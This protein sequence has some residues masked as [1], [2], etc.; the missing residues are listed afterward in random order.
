MIVPETHIETNAVC[1]HK[2][3]PGLENAP[4]KHLVAQKTEQWFLPDV[5]S[6]HWAVDWKCLL[7]V[8]DIRG[9]SQTDVGRSIIQVT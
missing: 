1:K 5:P 6:E 2:L 7:Q 8:T 9:I 4:S 3:T